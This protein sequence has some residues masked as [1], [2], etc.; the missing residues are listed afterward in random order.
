[1]TCTKK[2]Q[3]KYITR[4][5]PVYS[6]SDCKGMKKKGMMVAITHPHQ[7]KMVHING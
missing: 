7:I 4:N 6:A 1:M 5:S 3:T 2:T